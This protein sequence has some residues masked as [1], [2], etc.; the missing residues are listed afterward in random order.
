MNACLLGST[1]IMGMDARPYS[2][3]GYQR[4]RS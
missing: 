1:D 3:G 2:H 4:I